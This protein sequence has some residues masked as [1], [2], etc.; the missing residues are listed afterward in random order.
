MPLNAGTRLGHYEILEP[1]GEG[2]EARLG[3]FVAADDRLFA[4]VAAGHDQGVEMVIEEKMVQRCI[5]KHQAQARVA[6]GYGRGQGV[7]RAAA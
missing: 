6:R 7:V 3:F 5:R 2:A 4:H 1:V